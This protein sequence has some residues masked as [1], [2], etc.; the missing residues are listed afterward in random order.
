MRNDLIVLAGN[1]NAGKTSLFN[2]IT[3]ARQ[4]VANYPG[5]TVE[6]KEGYYSHDGLELHIVDLPG[7]YSLTA[8]SPEELVAREVLTLE[9]PRV[10]INI[11]D[12]SN[13][14]RNLYLTLQL[15]ELGIPVIIALNMMDVAE[16][17]GIEI[18]AGELS[19]K[20]NVP[21]IPT[22]AR[23]GKGKEELLAVAARVAR[24]GAG[25]MIPP[26][27]PYGPDIDPVLHE[28]EA[29]ISSSGL[30]TDLYPARWIALKYLE[31]DEEV[32][33]KGRAGYPEV[34]AELE[35]MV[36]RV[37]EHLRKTL[38][39]YPEGIIADYRY[40]FI[41]AV[42]KSGVLKHKHDADRLYLSDRIDLVLTHRL[43]GPLI[44]ALVLYGLYYF[45]FTGS[46]APVRWLQAGFA[47]LGGV[48]RTHLG[49][50]L[51]RSL[52]V[53]GIIDGVGGILGFVPIIIFIFLGIAFL[54]DSGYLARAAFMLDRVF[55]TFGLHGNSFM[56]YI[57]GGGIAGGCGVPG[58]MATRT[59]RSSNERLA[60]MLTIG[61]MNCGAKL[62]VYAL[63]I[64]AFF[65]RS[66]PQMMMLL[67]LISWSM[68][69]LVARFLRSTI[70]RGP[71]T[72]FLLE[73]PPYRLPTLRGL[74][75]HTWE[76]SWI[77]VRKAGTVLLAV[78]ILFWALMNFPR[79]SE[80]RNAAFDAQRRAL[81]AGLASTVKSPPAEV[82]GKLAG[83]STAAA[84]DAAQAREALRHSYAGRM[85]IALEHITRF[86][87]FDW[88]TNVALVG[89]V[90]GKEIVVSVL[91]TAYSMGR[92][93]S[94]KE[95]PL[96]A[97]LAADPAWNPLV[98]FTMILF[99]MFYVPCIVSVV[100]LAK[101]AGSWKWA[102]FSVV[103]NTSVAFLVAVLVYQ[104]GRLLGLGL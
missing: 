83:G 17:R 29:K 82:A 33:T 101:E 79:L 24:E 71:N 2:A 12:A 77:Y 96:G 47:A 72:P 9:S 87:G 102:L 92:T 49:P 89:G 60:T 95:A 16:G 100:C 4:H 91:S 31:A 43:A 38:D 19:R 36:A 88:R 15:F 34:S 78:S 21:V 70:L 39:T 84:I 90:A 14:D 65:A 37:A 104:G 93:G 27:I 51:L 50:G 73:L 7:T 48:I 46:D 55:R 11:V 26:Q 6:R 45:A 53:N 76:R 3:G 44:M 18:D 56:A 75:I 28:M 69:F 61:F 8:Y 59:L 25:S 1:P 86:C 58:V 20:L 68:A 5:V 97:V 42:L 13:L 40:G 32:V 98:A 67:T 23:S 62:P 66:K 57:V 30:L 52:L 22:V 80:S 103:F 41:S 54:E 99:T 63:L 85:G 74:A 64:G 81:V 94:G 10:V 35:K